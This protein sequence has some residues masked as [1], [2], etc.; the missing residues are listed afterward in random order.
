MQRYFCCVL[1]HGIAPTIAS[2]ALEKANMLH[3]TKES[4]DKD[5]ILKTQMLLPTS[6]NSIPEIL[7][8]NRSGKEMATFLMKKPTSILKSKIFQKILSV[9]STSGT[10]PQSR[11]AN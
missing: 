10:F 5:Q 2:G 1:G 11:E 3:M 4:I 8:E 7:A 6:V 9:T